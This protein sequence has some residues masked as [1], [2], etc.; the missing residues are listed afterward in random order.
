MIKKLFFIAALLV[1]GLAYGGPSANLAVQIVPAGVTGSILPPLPAGKT[2]WV[3]VTGDEFNGS[4][5]DLS[6]WDGT[7]ANGY[8]NDGYICQELS[9]GTEGSG[10]LTM[11][12]GTT[13]ECVVQPWTAT[14]SVCSGPCA[15]L[16]L[17][18]SFPPALPG[19]Y[20]PGYYEARL[21]SNAGYSAFWLQGNNGSC[22]CPGLTCGA[23]LD[24]MEGGSTYQN[25]IFWGGYGACG[26]QNP[27]TGLGP[28]GDMF[29]LLGLLWDP[30]GGY[31]HYLDGVATKHVAGPV[32]NGSGYHG[33]TLTTAGTNGGSPMVVD[34]VRYFQAR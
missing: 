14:G 20:K 2:Q 23:E 22:S 13:S 12:P 27:T 7:P 10:V 26:Q 1:P 33:V 29:H 3:Y 6:F 9:K 17:V 34:W 25:N 5:I 16:Q 32:D 19:G 24:I 31:T 30:V 8:P 18:S 28:I 4:S 21:P 15:G 11:I